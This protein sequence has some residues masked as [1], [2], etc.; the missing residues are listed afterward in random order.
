VIHWWHGKLTIE[1][2]E[3]V[4]LGRSSISF[5][6]IGK[7][8]FLTIRRLRRIKSSTTSR[9]EIPEIRNL[10]K[11]ERRQVCVHWRQS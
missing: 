9:E 1:E 3:A 2:G 8:E 6:F 11:K 5:L 4:N 7:C 10:I